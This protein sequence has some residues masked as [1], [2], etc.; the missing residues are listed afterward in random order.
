MRNK[1]RQRA[2]LES[3]LHRLAR[4]LGRTGF[5]SQGSV[6]ERKQRGGGSRYQWTW[7][8]PNQ[9][10]ASLTLSAKQFVWLQKAIARS[11]SVEHTLKQMRHISQR[12]LLEHLPGPRRRKPL[13]SKTLRAI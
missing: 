12:I 7:K 3:R 13:P 9:K 11:R 10:T 6:F 2:A 4:R 8:D 5:V 1:D